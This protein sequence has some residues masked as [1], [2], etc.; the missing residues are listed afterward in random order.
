MTCLG[1][2]LELFS[3]SEPLRLWNRMRGICTPRPAGLLGARATG[4]IGHRLTIDV[5]SDHDCIEPVEFLALL[6]LLTPTMLFFAGFTRIEL[7]IASC[8]FILFS[9]VA[10]ARKTVFYLDRRLRRALP[11]FL[12]VGLLLL[13]LSGTFGVVNH[14]GDWEKHF[15]VINFLVDHSWPPRQLATDGSCEVLRYYVAW[16]L[17]AAFLAKI[18]GLPLQNAFLGIWSLIGLVLLF[19]LISFVVP[20]KRG[21]YLG[22]VIFLLFGGLDLF[23]GMLVHSPLAQEFDLEWWAGW[24]QYGSPISMF[25]WGPQHAIFGWIATLLLIRQF[26]RLALT[27]QVGT[28]GCSVLLSSPF[29]ALG[30]L[31]VCVGLAASIGFRKVVLQWKSPGGLPDR[32]AA[33]CL[34]TR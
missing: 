18:T 6:Y 33:M 14:T 12:L 5:P 8:V 34:P 19:Y 16:Y 31:P 7:A 9:I 30:L 29:A 17:V 24:M 11:W 20:G 13:F 3:R 23:G 22:P 4:P 10:A 1:R 28:I 32:S 26:G 15:A 2:V 25:L 21:L 27:D